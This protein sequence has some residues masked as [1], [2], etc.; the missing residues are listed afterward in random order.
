MRFRRGVSIPITAEQGAAVAPQLR[1]PKLD[2][3]LRERLELVAGAARR[4]DVA[5][6]ARWSGRS[7][8]QL[9]VWRRRF[10]AGG[11]AALVDASRTGRPPPADA[12]YHAALERAVTTP[13]TALGF[14]FDVW[15]A[16]RLS[17]YLAETTGVRLTPGWLRTLLNRQPFVCGRPK[18]ALHHLQDADEVAAGAVELATVEA[19]VRAEPAHRAMHHHDETHRAT[20]PSLT[21]LWHRRGV[22]PTR[23]AAG[24]NR[25]L[26]VLGSVA[27]LGRGRV[28]VGCARQDWAG[29]VQYLAVLEERHRQ[30]GRQIHLVLDNE[31]CHRSRVSHAA[32]AAWADWLAVIWLSRSRPHLNHK[33]REWRYRKR[34]R[35]SHPRGLGVGARLSMRWWR[36]WGSWG[37]RAAIWWTW[38]RTGF[39]PAIASR[40][41]GD[42]WAG[43][44][45]RR[46][47]NR[48]SIDARTY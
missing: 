27:V 15:T 7:P 35:R 9:Q 44:Q 24:T 37:A 26:T 38:F 29:F 34:D 17:A 39:L 5:M 3:R 36:G 47:P 30:T 12:A 28:E 48:A 31:P 19:Q 14:P 42:Q 1:Q 10:V 32:L 40:P 4:Q 21:R 45:D 25:R 16:A 22:Q 18:H 46:T 33:E 8:R 43:P 41:P 11:S 20:N 23:P 6:I 2:R 13:P